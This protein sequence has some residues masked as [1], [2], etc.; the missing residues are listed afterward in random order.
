MLV[1]KG[2]GK[3][4]FSF[5]P[6]NKRSQGASDHGKLLVSIED[7]DYLYNPCLGFSRTYWNPGPHMHQLWNIH[8]D[9]FQPEDHIFSVGNKN[10]GL[11]FDP[12]IQEHVIVEIFIR[13]K[14]YKS[15]QYY[16][17]CSLW[18]CNRQVQQLPPPPLP[19]NDMPPAYLDGML[20]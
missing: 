13:V 6:L 7:K 10:V 18:S 9:Y 17:T 8:A 2:T 14:D 19:V 20:Y 1:G 4:G 12:L 15:R 3:L 5:S 16:L 11:G